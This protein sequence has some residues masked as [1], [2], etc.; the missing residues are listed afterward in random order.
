[1]TRRTL[2]VGSLYLIPLL[3]LAVFFFYPLLSIFAVS[4]VPEGVLDLS[5]LRRLVAS[6]YYARVLWFTFWQAAVS[7]VL[8]VVLALPGAYVFARYRF[9][10]K[11]LLRA[12]T[13]IPFVLPT[14]VVANAF[15]AW[16]GPHSRLNLAL[17]ALLGMDTA[18]IDLQHTIWIILLAHIF[19]N[20]AVVLRIVSGLWAN[21]SPRTEEAA[22]ML[23]ARPR[24]VLWQVTLPQLAPAIGAA[25]LLVFIFCFTSF[26][27]ILI[28]GGPRFAT[29][30]VEIYR[31][32]VNLFNLPVAAALSILQILFTFGLMW[33][34][35]HV[36]R[37]SAIQLD[38]RARQQIQRWPTTRRARLLVAAN[39]VLMVA[40]LLLPLLA[41]VE[42]SL[43]LGGG[44]SLRYYAELFVNRR[45]SILYVPPIQA[46]ANSLGFAA[47]TVG[48]ALALG[49]VSASLLSRPARER[50]IQR[51]QS[52]LDP[53]LML[54]LGT[55][56]VTLGFG[57]IIALDEPPLNL[58]TA[59]LL[60]PLAHTLVAFPFV[61]R[62]LLPAM[63]S[64]KPSLREAAAV[65]GASPLRLWREID[66]PIV[67]RA[68]LVAA[69]F[70]FTISMGEFG[71]TALIARP[72]TPTLP[73]AIYRFLGQPGALNYGQALAM[74]T[75]LM[76]VCAVG[77][78]AIEQF[79]V[80]GVGEF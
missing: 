21:I 32:T 48:L 64:I 76:L 26:G 50:G 18:P 30:E 43:T 4:F 22:Q 5:G 65:L 2:L 72:Q 40:G 62:S 44:L 79:R 7:T 34:Y 61:V 27:V 42:R 29:L 70:A 54:P 31:Q 8:T 59:P 39:V 33:V 1:V 37:R 55:S 11:W 78:V 41:L 75:L 53:L 38:L 17:M 63:R 9:P 71:A 45:D 36:Q 12:L 58:R 19:F 80:G 35:T 23:G 52:L 3:F 13:T 14:V 73:V 46:L 57:F 60:V 49:I 10:G 28:L 69:V 15:T 66:L 77:M 6:D 56:A 25:A 20:Y 68:L 51:L 24:D 16:L 47:V 74:S 67:G